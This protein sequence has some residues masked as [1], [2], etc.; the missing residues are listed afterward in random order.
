MGLMVPYWYTIWCLSVYSILF[1]HVFISFLS[2]FFSIFI[3]LV[4][5]KNNCHQRFGGLIDQR[6]V[7][8]TIGYINPQNEIP[9]R[10]CKDEDHYYPRWYSFLRSRTDTQN[11][12][13][14]HDR[15][16]SWM[17]FLCFGNSFIRDM[18][19]VIPD[20]GWVKRGLDFEGWTSFWWRRRKNE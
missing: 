18:R 10:N 19:V 2:F 6:A 8:Q 20:Q 14:L 13:F 9:G 5:P 15:F 11:R 3:I 4:H 12:F 7:R 1:H 16:L 17:L